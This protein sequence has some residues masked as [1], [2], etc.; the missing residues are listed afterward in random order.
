MDQSIYQKTGDLRGLA[1]IRLLVLDDGA[2]RG[3]RLLIARNGAGISFEVAVDR[4]FD[5]S[6]LSAHGV[7]L[8]WNSPNQMRFPSLSAD[9]DE[10]WGFF[11]NFDGFLVSCGL[12]HY[13]L[14]TYLEDAPY[15]HP[16]R[17][18]YLEPMH[19]KLHALQGRLRGYGIDE[20]KGVIWCEGTVRQVAIYGEVLQLDRRIE[21]P[22]QGDKI[23]ITDKVSNKGFQPSP[24][25][26]LYHFNIGYPLLDESLTI[27]GVA[28]D[29]AR[30]FVENPPIPADKVLEMVDPIPPLIEADGWSRVRVENAQLGKARGIEFAFQPAELPNLTIWRCYQPGVFALGVEPNTGVA[31]HDGKVLDS[32]ILDAGEVR[33][34]H[35]ELRIF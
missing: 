29:F 4:G 35:L 31:I 25:A 27:S 26:L 12:D 30:A 21:L 19:G 24:H 5:L 13:G 6:H 8:G 16:H 33:H 20:E 23:S 3:Q 32:H 14:P 28:D 15:K 10:G 2:G 11:Q 17:K 7:N 9:A 22:L 18:R 1:D 34:Y